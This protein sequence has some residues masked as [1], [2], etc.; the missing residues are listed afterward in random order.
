MAQTGQHE[1]VPILH[2]KAVFVYLDSRAS[3]VLSWKMQIALAEY[4]D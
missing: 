1:K 4:Y 2:L 3:A